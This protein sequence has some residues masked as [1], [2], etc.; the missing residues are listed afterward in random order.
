MLKLSEDCAKRHKPGQPDKDLEFFAL[1][2]L[3]NIEGYNIGGYATE[4]EADKMRTL[5]ATCDNY[6]IGGNEYNRQPGRQSAL[7]PSTANFLDA[8]L[9][10]AAEIG[11][12]QS[13]GIASSCAGEKYKG[14]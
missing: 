6:R 10:E 4:Q 12:P 9:I 11:Y 8:A 5:A 2:R 3:K 1:M 14:D 13:P 7:F